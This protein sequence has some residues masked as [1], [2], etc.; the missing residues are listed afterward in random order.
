[1]LVALAIMSGAPAT[2]EADERAVFAEVAPAAPF[3]AS[4]LAAAIR[5]R[6]P[7]GDVP[8]RV[9]VFGTPGGVRVEA[10]GNARE[11]ALGGLTGA[12][13]ARLVALVLDDLLLDDLATV[14]LAPPSVMSHAAPARARV[15]IGVLGS[16]TVW[17]YALGGLGLDVAIPRDPWLLAIEA[18]GSALVDGPLHLTTAMVRIVGGARV[19]PL[20]LRLGASVA[21]V[22]VSDGVHDR[23][24]LIGAGTSARLRAPLSAGVRAVLAGGVDV[25]ATRTTYIV[26]GMAVLATPRAAPWIAAGVEVTP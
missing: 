9:R 7:A 5:L 1:M 12:P 3:D 20:E 18:G 19:G 14:P 13:A 24:L 8:V 4:Q 25:F 21:P 23:T 22:L 10:R 17:Q 11:I 2:V 15:N 16:A 6:L 26:D